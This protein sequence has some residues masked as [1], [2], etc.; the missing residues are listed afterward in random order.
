VLR[1][2]YNSI[3]N[4]TAYLISFYS[5]LAVGFALNALNLHIQKDL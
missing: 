1:L 5:R 2:E 4:L 3:E